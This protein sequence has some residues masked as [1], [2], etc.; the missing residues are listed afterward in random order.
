METETLKSLFYRIPTAEIAK[1]RTQNPLFNISIHIDLFII[2][3]V[4]LKKLFFFYLKRWVIAGVGP[5]RRASGSGQRF[6]VFTRRDS[7][8]PATSRW[9]IGILTRVQLWVRRRDLVQ[10]DYIERCWVSTW[11]VSNT[12]IPVTWGP[13]YPL[14]Q[15]FSRSKLISDHWKGWL[16][17]ITVCSLKRTTNYLLRVGGWLGN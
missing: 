14:C 8:R 12:V 4:L 17:L 10:W 11:H 1:P 15:N 2:F 9:W 6:R 16:A 13:R 5:I 7:V 3:W